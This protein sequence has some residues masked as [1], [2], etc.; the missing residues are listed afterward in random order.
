MALYDAWVV[1]AETARHEFTARIF[2][3]IFGEEEMGDVAKEFT[4]SEITT[5]LMAYE[6]ELAANGLFRANAEIQKEV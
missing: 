4:P 5:I 2:P 6:H 1:G 3:T